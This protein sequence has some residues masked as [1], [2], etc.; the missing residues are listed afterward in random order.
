M[1]ANTILN[2]IS[3]V[4]QHFPPFRWDDEQ[5]KSWVE[6]MKS[7]LKG[8]SDE[9]LSRAIVDLIRTR[10]DRRIPLPAECIS[11][12]LE[13]RR[14]VETEN[15]KSSLPVG[16]QDGRAHLDWTTERLK[17]ADDLVMGSMG[18]QAAKEGWVGMLHAYARKNSRLP[19]ESEIGALKRAA[20]EFDETYA[21]CVRGG[22]APP[23]KRGPQQ[24][25]PFHLLEKL[26]A[27]MLKRRE[28]IADRVLHGVVR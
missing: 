14:W 23:T 18:R 10:K 28:E 26:G 3:R 2:F 12:C 27:S 22:N 16:D 21:M 1:S 7:E 24:V 13:A 17:L 25:A 5:E 9:V 20:K 6:T 4:I 8:F 11:A 15:Q 19:P